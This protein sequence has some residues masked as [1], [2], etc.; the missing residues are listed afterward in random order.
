MHRL[1][2]PADVVD[3]A[4]VHLAQAQDAQPDDPGEPARCAGCAAEGVEHWAHLR[5]CLSCGYVGC[6][7]SSP[8]RHATNHYTE[9]AHPVMRS[10]EPGETWRWCYVDEQL[11]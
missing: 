4:C 1:I 11:G 10:A 8:R 2:R 7:D 6:C 3:D 9:T 5:R